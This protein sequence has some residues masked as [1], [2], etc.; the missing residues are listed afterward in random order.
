MEGKSVLREVEGGEGVEFEMVSMAEVDEAAV[1]T[2]ALASDSV[3][4]EI[5][6]AAEVLDSEEMLATLR[7]EASTWPRLVAPPMKRSG[8]VIMDACCANGSSAFIT[9]SQYADANSF[10]SNL[11][12]DLPQVTLET[13]LPRCS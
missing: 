8:H 11:T 13:G 10:R 5:R 2:E 12:Y 4:S 9:S 3:E 6:D 1:E 7:E